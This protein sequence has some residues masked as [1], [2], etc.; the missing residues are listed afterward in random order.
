MSMKKL[1]LCAMGFFYM[2]VDAAPSE[3]KTSTPMAPKAIYIPQNEQDIIQ[4]FLK[5]VQF[6]RVG[7]DDFF[8]TIFNSTLYAERFLPSCFVHVIDFF[9]YGKK[10]NKPFSFY[11]SVFNLFHHRLKESQWV[12]TYALLMFMEQLPEYVD[13]LSTTHHEKIINL[14]KIE[15]QKAI[16]DRSFLL[17]DRAESFYTETAENI[18]SSL[19]KAEAEGSLRDLQKSCTTFLEH[20]CGKLIW[21]PKE[22]EDIWKTIKLLSNK[23]ELLLQLGCLT[24]TDDLNRLL[25]SL[26]YRFSYFIDCAGNQ[27]PLEFY[28]AIR[29]DIHKEMPTFLKVEESEKWIVPKQKYIMDVLDKGEIKAHAYK[30]G[31]FADVR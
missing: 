2:L 9:E 3:H 20:C 12:N 31:I 30:Q 27:L 8:R 13:T 25:W 17:K 6:T 14:L 23:C 10:N 11:E 5:P 7:M 4:S 15:L 26:L 28:Q 18:M 19:K 21:S 29:N 22:K 24:N 16:N 1:F